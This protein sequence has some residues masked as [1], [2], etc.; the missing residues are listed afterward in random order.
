MGEAS[1]PERAILN[2]LPTAWIHFLVVECFAI[3]ASVGSW[4]VLVPTIQVNTATTSAVQ[5]T[6]FQGY[7]RSLFFFGSASGVNVSYTTVKDMYFIANRSD[8]CSFS[9]ENDCNTGIQWVANTVHDSLSTCTLSLPSTTIDEASNGLWLAVAWTLPFF[10]LCFIAMLVG[11][12][13]QSGIWSFDS[14]A[15]LEFT[16]DLYASKKYKL[17]GLSMAIGPICLALL[18]AVQIVMYGL[19][20]KDAF[21]K[22]FP[23]I[24]VLILAVKTICIPWVEGHHFNT[25][26]PVNSQ[27]LPENNALHQEFA[28]LKIERRLKHLNP[29]DT[30]GHNAVFSLTVVNAMWLAKNGNPRP[31]KSITFIS[32]DGDEASAYE[33]TLAVFSAYEE[34]IAKQRSASNTEMAACSSF[35]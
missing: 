2:M 13:C 35:S 30:S 29:T 32:A 19:D 31:L 21:I 16:S 26:A 7:F 22:S 4:V 8:N 11:S 24:F 14:I 9:F 17:G 18:W 20:Q 27:G 6:Q 5:T 23:S 3:W 1:A 34:K 15:Y 33:R 28:N 12:L 25:S 10:T